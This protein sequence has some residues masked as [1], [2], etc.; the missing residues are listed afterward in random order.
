MIYKKIKEREENKALFELRRLQLLTQAIHSTEP[1]NFIDELEDIINNEPSK[2]IIGDLEELE[3]L[4]HT[5][6]VV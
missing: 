6:E 3:K 5:R 4:K 1:Q 2:E